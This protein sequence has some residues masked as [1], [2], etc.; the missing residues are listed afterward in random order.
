MSKKA[1]KEKFGAGHASAMGRQGLRE[2][3]AAMYPE[4]NVAQPT[5][6]G[7]YGNKTP[8]EI[9][10]ERDPEKGE[11]DK[12]GDQEPRSTLK[13]CLNRAESQ[14]EASSRDNRDLSKE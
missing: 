4:S 13:D 14:R 11:H 10:D 7:I 6:Y 2:L 12:G 5:D 1:E 8:G 3:R 9:A